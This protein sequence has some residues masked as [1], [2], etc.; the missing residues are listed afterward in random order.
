ML[1]KEPTVYV[2]KNGGVED[3][4][5][6]LAR[7]LTVWIRAIAVTTKR[8]TIENDAMWAKLLNYYKQRL[9]IYAAQIASSSELEVAAAFDGGSDGAALARE[10]HGLSVKYEA[11]ESVA[12]LQDMV[13]A[14]YSL[15]HEP[16]SATPAPS[17]RRLMNSVHFLGR[18]RSAYEAFKE[19]AIVFRT[20]FAKL[21]IVCIEAPPARLLSKSLVSKRVEA[22][23]REHEIPQPTKDELQKSLGKASELSTPCHAEMQLLIHLECSLGPS[24]KPFPYLGCSK[25]ACWLCHELLSRYKDKR[26]DTKGFYQ[27]RGSH[28]R[29]YPLWNITLAAY[30]QA[31]HRI[32][33][34]LSASLRGIETLMF[35]RLRTVSQDRLPAVAES[36]ANVTVTGGALKRRALA[37][38]RV[39]ESTKNS[40]GAES[41]IPTLKDSV[42]SKTCMR[43]PANGE[44]PHLLSIKFYEHPG[45]LPGHEPV[46]FRIPDFGAFWNASNFDRAHRRVT[47]EAQPLAELN[48]EYLLYWCRSDALPPNECLMSLLG[49]QSLQA[50]EHFWHGDVF[51]TRYREDG[52]FEFHCEDVPRASLDNMEWIKTTIR[53]FWDR[54]EPENEIRSW[55]KVDALNEKLSADK[56]IIYSKMS[57]TER[58][59]LKKVPGMLDF[60]AFISS[61]DG[62]TDQRGWK[63]FSSDSL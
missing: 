21:N 37:K 56:E 45:D 16:A 7:S 63:G 24:A 6:D 46:T 4:D 11:D 19:A 50:D 49:L 53:A 1:N 8:P 30:P 35:E 44:P 34:D 26:T 28:G 3:A 32:R 27:T 47:V 57:A 38:S 29:V 48:G 18:L 62:A 31:D 43:I 17:G 59:K 51:I 2:A 12:V 58:E 25:K 52:E 40:K 61:D 54:R 23:A 42:C 20:S 33:L 39:A 55:Q 5:K 36:S 15:R 10:L 22:L 13:F 60:L 14:A 9:D 41:Q